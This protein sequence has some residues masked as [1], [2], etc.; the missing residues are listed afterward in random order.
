[1]RE[2]KLIAEETRLALTGE[3]GASQMLLMLQKRLITA[4]INSYISNLP[5][6]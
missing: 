2:D 1:M 3:A 6:S 5:A 4:G